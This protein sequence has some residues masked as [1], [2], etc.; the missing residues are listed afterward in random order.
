MSGLVLC[1][2]LTIRAGGVKKRGERGEARAQESGQGRDSRPIRS[3]ISRLCFA[4]LDMTKKRS[5]F[6]FPE[7]HGL[8]PGVLCDARQGFPNSLV[9]DRIVGRGGGDR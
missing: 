7:R 9:A 1:P 5:F 8:P 6:Q 2:I 3:Q 4:P